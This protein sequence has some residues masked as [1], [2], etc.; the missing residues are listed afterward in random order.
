MTDLQGA[1][2]QT[3]D[4]LPGATG[5]A[6]TPNGSSLWVAVPSTGLARIDTTTLAV[7]QRI[8]LPTGQCAG[9]VAVVVARLVCGHSCSTYGESGPYGGLGVVA[10]GLAGQVYAADSSTGP[11]DLSLY[12]VSGA[13]PV[14]VAARAAG[15]GDLRELSAQPDGSQTVARSWR[16]AGR[17]TSTRPGRP[18]DSSRSAAPP[19]APVR[20]RAP[21]QRTA[22]AS[23]PAWSP[24]MSRTSPSPSPS[25]SPRPARRRR[26]ASSTSARRR[27]S[28]NR[29]AWRRRPTAPARGR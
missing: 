15:C 20:R 24:R 11:T 28:C 25:P 5:L 19:A 12:D 13:A 27:S 10:A 3:V 2:V 7:T 14:L 29:G 17:R 21:G 6:L 9:D 4:G 18:T 8:I 16:P 22:S 1:P 23:S 26:P